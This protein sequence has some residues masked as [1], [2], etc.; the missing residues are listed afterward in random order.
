MTKELAIVQPQ[1]PIWTQ[2]QVDMIKRQVARDATDDELGMFLHYC[3]SQGLDPL[4]KDVYFR[5]GQSKDGRASIAYITSIDTYRAR[6]AD[7]GEHAGTDDAVFDDELK[8]SRASVT[9]YRLVGGVRCPFTATARWSEYYPGGRQAFMWDKMPTGQLAKC[10]EALALRKAFPKQF[11]KLYVREEMD[12]AGAPND[13]ETVEHVESE[14]LYDRSNAE[15][16]REMVALAERLGFR[17]TPTQIR[18]VV[19]TVDGLPLGERERVIREVANKR[20]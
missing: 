7:T 8:P 18:L 20:N 19:Q 9:V 10:A 3:A 6:A 12:Q 5:K 13:T 2:D 15:H 4:A 1:Q 17:L 11:K 14:T 16:N